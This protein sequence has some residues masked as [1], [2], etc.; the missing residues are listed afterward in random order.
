MEEKI[1]ARIEQLK[2]ELQQYLAQANVQ[3][4]AYRSAIGE[5][6]QLLRPEATLDDNQET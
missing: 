5:L 2:Q 1:K 3:V 4:T 6:E